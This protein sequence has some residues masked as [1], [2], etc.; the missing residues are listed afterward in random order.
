MESAEIKKTSRKLA[1]PFVL[2]ALVLIVAIL[3]HRLGSKKSVPQAISFLVG[4]NGVGFACVFGFRLIKFWVFLNR[5]K[6]SE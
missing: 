3:F 2:S 5:N 6:N 1:I 4:L